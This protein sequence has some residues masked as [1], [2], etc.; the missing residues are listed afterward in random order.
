VRKDFSLSNLWVIRH[1]E[2]ELN[3]RNVFMG[4]RDVPS[5]R[6]GLDRAASIG[7]SLAGTFQYVFSSPLCRAAETA[8][9]MFPGLPIEHDDRL[10][11]RG[12]GVWEGLPKADVRR[13]HPWAFPNSR[14]D[15][16]YTPDGGEDV[17]HLIARVESFL[18]DVAPLTR[19]TRVALVSHNV[20][21]RTAES[22]CI[23][24]TPEYIYDSRIEQLAP[25]AI[26]VPATWCRPR[27]GAM[28]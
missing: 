6:E 5:T 10:R 25:K 11:E 13:D 20:W 12:M 14:L 21:I 7:R 9:A 2:T 1:A 27:V 4:D 28:S 15:A 23:G 3:I 26:T 19:T 24:A 22:V 17:S 8:S 16:S 18:R